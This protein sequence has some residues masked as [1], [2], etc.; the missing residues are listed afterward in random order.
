ML[1]RSRVET[2]SRVQYNQI[3]SAIKASGR[4]LGVLPACVVGAGVVLTPRDKVI[5]G[6][7]VPIICIENLACVCSTTAPA[8]DVHCAGN[9]GDSAAFRRPPLTPS[10]NILC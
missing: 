7:L 8:A 3:L 6:A 9:A 4:K 1:S 2:R 5:G 10:A